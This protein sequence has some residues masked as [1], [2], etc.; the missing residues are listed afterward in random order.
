VI[1]E[2]SEPGLEVSHEV[3]GTL[4]GLETPLVDI[5]NE[6]RIEIRGHGYGRVVPRGPDLHLKGFTK[7][8]TPKG[9]SIF[10][11]TLGHPFDVNP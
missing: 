2:I 6:I 7:E 11:L 1:L 8:R 4:P 3:R 10:K 9:S 5:G